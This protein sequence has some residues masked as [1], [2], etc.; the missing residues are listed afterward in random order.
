MELWVSI[1]VLL[2][3]CCVVFALASTIVRRV[4]Q[5]IKNVAAEEWP[6][7]SK[8]ASATASVARNSSRGVNGGVFRKRSRINY[9]ETCLEESAV[10]RR[11]ASPVID[12][13][14][15][16]QPIHHTRSYGCLSAISTVSKAPSTALDEN[17][18][19]CKFRVDSESNE[20][21]EVTSTPVAVSPLERYQSDAA[22]KPQVVVARKCTQEEDFSVGNEVDKES[23]YEKQREV[24]IVRF[25]NTNFGFILRNT[26]V[27]GKGKG[28]SLFF[29]KDDIIG[30]AKVHRGDLVEYAVS[31]P[32]D[33][34]TGNKAKPKA[35]SIVVL[36]NTATAF[37]LN[38]AAPPFS[39]P[40]QPAARMLREGYA[41]ERFRSLPHL[42]SVESFENAIGVENSA[43]PSSWR[44]E[45]QVTPQVF[46]VS[47]AVSGGDLG[48]V[49]IQGER[50][51]ARGATIGAVGWDSALYPDEDMSRLLPVGLFD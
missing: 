26:R 47:P 5:H 10:S 31:K 3:V 18:E 46:G 23:S 20:T 21:E 45:T 32:R 50:F 28:N 1:L 38:P 7:N 24:G 9:L 4:V 51:R 14:S 2:C 42:P 25:V 49:P 36:A 37:D 43:L 13:N 40:S 34:A 11:R 27:L 12:N 39:I 33:G 29:L 30:S 22:C 15:E 8:A 35:E 41:R 48:L 6:S 19:V 17:D 16:A 44:M